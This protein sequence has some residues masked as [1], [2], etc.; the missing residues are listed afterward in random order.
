MEDPKDRKADEPSLDKAIESF[1]QGIDALFGTVERAVDRTLTQAEE[2]IR[3]RADSLREWAREEEDTNFVPASEDD[4]PTAALRE[5]AVKAATEA[6]ERAARFAKDTAAGYQRFVEGTKEAVERNVS[7]GAS[8]VDETL[9]DV[10]WKLAGLD[11]RKTRIARAMM[12]DVM[13]GVLGGRAAS[14]VDGASIKGG[15]VGAGLLLRLPLKAAA[16]P[17]LL[18]MAALET[19]RTVREVHGKLGEVTAK[20]DADIASERATA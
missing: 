2:A 18:G 10:P 11:E 4:D 17:V 8:A 12:K 7:K 5:A 9:G 13:P 1:G 19:Y 20:V 16:A 6:K 14:I 3:K 15:L